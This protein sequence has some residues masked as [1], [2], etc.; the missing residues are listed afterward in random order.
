[1]KKLAIC[2]F[3]AIV[4]LSITIPAMSAPVSITYTGTTLPFGVPLGLEAYFNAGDSVTIQFTLDDSGPDF[5]IPG[6]EVAVYDSKITDVLIRFGSYETMIPSINSAQVGNDCT[7][8]PPYSP[9][10]YFNVISFSGEVSSSPTL[11]GPSLGTWEPI[12]FVL[13][14][15]D[16]TGTA[17]HSLDLPL[18]PLDPNDFISSYSYISL[19]F[20]EADT[21]FRSAVVADFSPVPLPASVWLLSSCLFGLI[22]LV[23]YKKAA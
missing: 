3:Y 8:Q 21:G 5:V 7:G 9:K 13:Q 14:I 17:L 18:V 23:R 11:T 16:P 2:A 4:S 15:V 1:M 12:Q 10:D 20:K 6:D 22:S 19:T